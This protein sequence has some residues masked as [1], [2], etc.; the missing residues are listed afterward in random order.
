MSAPT[1][2]FPRPLTFGVPQGQDVIALK[3]AVSRAGLWPWTNFDGHYT[4]AFSQAVKAFQ[5]QKHLTVDGTYGVKTHN[6]LRATRRDGT[7]TQWAFDSTAI[8]LMNEAFLL[9]HP[10]VVAPCKLGMRPRYLH[11]TGGIPGNWALDWMQP[12]GT[13]LYAPCDMTVT[14]LSG[15]NPTTG[16]HGAIGDVFGWSIHFR[17]GKGRTYFATHMGARTVT[18]GQHIRVGQKFGEVGHWPHDPGRSHMHMGVDAGTVA[19][20]QAW[21]LKIANAPR[22]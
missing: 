7:P 9:E 5:K 1:V 2:P 3:R 19:A 4:K 18:D 13:S 15:H 14:Q 8:H 17:D 11:P 22:P 6:A 12:G 21:I 10:G 20:S 16:T